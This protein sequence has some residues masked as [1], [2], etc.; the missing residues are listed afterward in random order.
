LPIAA[1]QAVAALSCDQPSA[2]PV[3]PR[4]LSVTRR[5]SARNAA[6]EKMLANPR[7]KKGERH[8]K[9]NPRIEKL[10]P[11]AGTATQRGNYRVALARSEEEVREAQRLRYKVFVEELGAHVQTRLPT[12]TSTITTASATT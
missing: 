6:T 4:N 5:Q 2:N 10:A 3:T 12:T 9:Q 1:H 7:E 8:A 11:A